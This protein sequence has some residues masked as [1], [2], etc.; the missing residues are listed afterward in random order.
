ELLGERRKLGG[1]QL[2]EII[3]TVDGV[4]HGVF[5]AGHCGELYTEP[6]APIPRVFELLDTAYDELCKLDQGCAAW[7]KRGQRRDCAIAKGA[8][9]VACRGQTHGTGVGRFA[10]RRVRP[11]GLPEHG[12]IALHI[13][14]VILDL[15]SETDLVTK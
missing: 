4:E 5:G 2:A 13:Q 7:P 10:E 12:H 3:R 6:S 8:S 1:R 11:R 15:E 9:P 14:D